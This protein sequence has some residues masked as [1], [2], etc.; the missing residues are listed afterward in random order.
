MADARSITRSLRG[1]WHGSYG[2]VCCPA[3]KDKTP[4]LKVSD[5]HNDIIVHCFA[6]CD[7]RDVK[8]E[9]VRRGLIEPFKPNGLVKRSKSRHSRLAFSLKKP[10]AEPNPTRQSALNIWNQAQVDIIGTFGDL[11]LVNRAIGLTRNLPFLRFHPALAHPETPRRKWP[12]LIFALT[13]LDGSFDG[14]QRIYIDPYTAQKASLKSPKM[15][16]G[17]RHG[18]AIRMGE[19]RL[20]DG[21]FDALTITGGPEDGL[22]L[23]QDGEEPVWVS[24]GEYRLVSIDVPAPLRQLTIAGDNDEVGRQRARQTAGNCSQSVLRGSNGAPN[25]TIRFPPDGYKDF[26]AKAVAEMR[27]SHPP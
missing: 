5:G 16:L 2:M 13:A 25:I 1:R 21:F 6:G 7:W 26:N 4:S 17:T 22:S 18:S 8:K 9:L 20:R 15:T 14:I 27:R 23:L 3:H 24:C 12:A 19:P 11:Y 10:P